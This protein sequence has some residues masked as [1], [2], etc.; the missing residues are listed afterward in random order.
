MKIRFIALLIPTFFIFGES[1]SQSASKSTIDDWLLKEQNLQYDYLK[2]FSTRQY[3]CE[4]KRSIRF[5]FDI[6][7]NLW[8]QELNRNIN[9]SRK[10]RLT[11]TKSDDIKERVGLCG[12]KDQPLSSERHLYKY[13]CIVEKWNGGSTHRKCL[14][15]IDENYPK[16]E[17][18]HTLVCGNS[19]YKFN[20]T[21]G[22]VFDNDFV[23]GPYSSY[24]NT[25]EQGME[26]SDCMRFGN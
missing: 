14:L 3:I 5:I 22:K 25:L 2:N 8:R 7:K 11:I 17:F 12:A 9:T 6:E 16:G 13:F 15:E 23:I 10:N 1:F 20:L 19:G 21:H 24:G 26:V 18:I 4:Q